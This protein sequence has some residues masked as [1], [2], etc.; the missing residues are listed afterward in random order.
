MMNPALSVTVKGVVLVG[1]GDFVVS[2]SSNVAAL[3]YNMIKFRLYFFKFTEGIEGVASIC[4]SVFEASKL[5]GASGA[6]ELK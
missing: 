1:D 2:E 3:T 6:D 5:L 4:I